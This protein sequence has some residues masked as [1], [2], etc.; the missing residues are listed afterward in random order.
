ML[1]GHVF[2]W[3]IQLGDIFCDLNFRRWKKEDW[4]FLEYIRKLSNLKRGVETESWT[5]VVE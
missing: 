3:Q 2:R 4:Q 1:D 5:Q